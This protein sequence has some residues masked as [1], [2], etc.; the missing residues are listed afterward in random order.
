MF[1][2]N[3]HILFWGIFMFYSKFSGQK[4]CPTK[5]F[6][7]ISQYPNIQSL[8]AYFHMRQKNIYDNINKLLVLFVSRMFF[9]PQEHLSYLRDILSRLSKGMVLTRAV[10]KASL[11]Q[12]LILHEV[13]LRFGFVSGRS[14]FKFHLVCQL[15]WVSREEKDRNRHPLQRLLWG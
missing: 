8:K 15:L 4:K 12:Y 6:I 10:E 7:P 14:G 11:V 2:K 9:Y 5:Y 3:F 13:F 1:W